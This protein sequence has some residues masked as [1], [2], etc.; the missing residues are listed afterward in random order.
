MTIVMG[1]LNVTPDSF[2]DGGRWDATDAAIERGLELRAQ[3]AALVDVGGE[4]TRPGAAKVDPAEERQRVVPVVAALAESGVAVSIDT[5]HADTARAAIDAGA[6]FVNDVSGGL[7]DPGMARVVAD[8]GVHFAVMH[9]RGG[10]DVAADFTDVVAEVRAEL[11]QRVAELVVAGVD[12]AKIVLDPGLGFAK[13]AAHT[14]ALLTHLDALASLGHGLL[15]GASRKRFVGALLPE[16]APMEDR[17]LPS[18]VIAALVAR[19]GAWAVRVHDVP[20]TL[21]AL[22]VEAAGREARDA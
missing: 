1:I 22:E 6:Q 16:D 3:G 19:Q 11:K 2:S 9:W 18:A 5:M 10:A 4:S 21:L 15:V 7:A 8:S 13:D 12:P 17:D 20:S 14:W